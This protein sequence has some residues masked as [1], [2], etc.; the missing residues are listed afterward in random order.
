[1][2]IHGLVGLGRR[3]RIQHLFFFCFTSAA[4]SPPIFL[5]LSRKDKRTRLKKR[6]TFLPILL[7]WA[8]AL[9]RGLGDRREKPHIPFCYTHTHTH[10]ERERDTA[11]APLYVDIPLTPQVVPG[12][13]PRRLGNR[14][15]RTHTHTHSHTNF[16]SSFSCCMCVPFHLPLYFSF[17]F[18]PFF[19]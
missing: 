7:H 1:M 6:K 15:P 19:L 4:C 3:R 14:R 11:R 17:L 12:V 16:S 18:I 5:T 10:T 13:A 9:R 2:Y 8:L